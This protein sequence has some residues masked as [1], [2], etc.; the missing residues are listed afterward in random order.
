MAHVVGESRYQRS[1]VA[2]SLDEIVC[3]D[4]PVRVIDAFVDGLDLNG[5][6]FSKV[7]AEATGRPPYRPADLLK[8][9]VYGYLNRIRSSRS[10]EREAVRNIE[11]QWLVNRVT[12]SFKTIADFR[13]EHV[14][15]IIG[16]CRS[17][18]RF[19]RGQSLYGGEL[20]ALDGTKIEAVASRKKVITPKELE[21]R[22]AKLD[23]RIADHLKA[24]DQADREE[25]AAE[26]QT[27]PEDV[28][29]ALASLR[30]RREEI[31]AQARDLAAAG[32][33][34]KVI[35]EDEARLMKTARHGHQVAYNAQSVVDD[36]HGLIAQFD[37]INDCNDQAQL[38]P[39][40]QA[41]KE[42]L[43]VE[44]LAVVA[45]TGYSNGEQG[46]ACASA[47]ITAAVPRQ[48]TV[49][50]RNGDLFSRE[51]F[52]YDAASDSWT[53]PAGEILSL[54]CISQT[55]QEKRYSTTAC[56]GCALKPKCT[57]AQSRQITRHLYED[58]RQ[59]MHRRTIENPTLMKQRR[60]LAEHPFGTIKWMLGYP[61]FLLRG[62]QK[63]K[64][65][66]A[67]AVLGFNLKRVTAIL[68]IPAL[69]EAL[70]ANPL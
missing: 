20:V 9:Y 21:K 23:A 70:K 34:Q 6:K 33:S 32:L 66:L 54:R 4:H 40:A 10:L 24:M 37:L 45:D 42:A 38:L 17:F 16:V 30:V 60:Q 57:K 68:G 43:E 41:A 48:K 13:K 36:K 46:E 18:I 65:E 14:E 58:A 22:M 2:S 52:S 63:A 51:A 67:L 1:L 55:E 19:C 44:S 31:Q 28:A 7:E 49:N 50:A 59:A 5:L 35:G 12:P 15:A 69:L 47:G 27:R 25:A 11:V 29:K 61:R 53:C 39:M 8:L 64:A 56:G 62:L 3:G 26:A